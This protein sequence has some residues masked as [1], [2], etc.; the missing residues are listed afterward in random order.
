[1]NAGYCG[2]VLG[3]ELRKVRRGNGWTRRQLQ[4]RLQDSGLELGL[5]TL[6]TYEL[7]TRQC[8]VVRLMQ[9]CAVLGISPDELLA[10]VRRRMAGDAKILHISLRQVSTAKSVKLRPVRAW[11][12]LRLRDMGADED[13]LVDLSD[14]AVENLARLCG[15]ESGELVGH[16]KNGASR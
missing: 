7:G 11:A 12:E 15:L 16:L 14:S 9:L 6:A 4:R 1:M 3:E 2:R 8:S 5:P 10:R 13:L